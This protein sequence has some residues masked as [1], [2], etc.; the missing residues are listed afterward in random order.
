MQRP[1]TLLPSISQGLADFAIR[2][3]AD[4]P[5]LARERAVDAI[6]D[7]IGCMLA[8][9][10]EPVASVVK[11]VVPT[12]LN[13]VRLVGGDAHAS[14]ADSALLHG[15]LAHALDFD[16]TNHPAYAHPGAVLVPVMLAFAAQEKL[17]GADLVSA[18][19]VGFQIFG[20]L[21]RALNFEHYRRG[22]HATST[23]GTLAAAAV[24]AR[25][26]RLDRDRATAAIGIA[27]SE[28][29][30][31]R[32]N[33]GSMVKPLHAGLAARNGVLAALLAQAGM[34]ASADALDHAHGFIKVFNNGSQPDLDALA[35]WYAPLEILGE[36]A[37]ALK[38]YPA[39][40]A[41]HPAIEAAIA[42][43]ADIEGKAID[44]II[45]HATERAFAPL[46][47][48]V[49][50]TPL[51]AKFS[52]HFCVAAALHDGEVNLATFSQPSIDDPS[53]R[54][55][56]GKVTMVGDPSLSNQTEFPARVEVRTVDGA[57]YERS[58]ALAL[59]KPSRW[60]SKAQLRGK[61]MDCARRTLTP[62]VAAAAFTALQSIDR[63]VA[64]ETV[65]DSLF[66]RT[67]ASQRQT[68]WG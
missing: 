52:M 11:A 45:V 4:F 60:F 54:Q 8:G 55:L 47:H 6:T 29:S 43:R 56:M 63:D 3:G 9:A 37:L 61:F 49:P 27:A 38:A 36:N 15:T 46:R 66:A 32:A 35:D 44:S 67:A 42:L 25:L 68:A 50:H 18:Y 2:A 58:V 23:F 5:A 33:F 62:G 12:V 57:V 19:I 21:G 24:A 53:I 16:D 20:K 40:G 13:G 30:G 41:T 65:L 48:V 39:C 22:W 10:S 64:A 26:L 31:V 1:L 28:A 14:P 34:T 7:C 17:R 59:G 51:E